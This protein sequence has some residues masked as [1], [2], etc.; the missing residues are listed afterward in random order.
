MLHDALVESLV[1]MARLCFYR[2]D[3]TESP[4]TEDRVSPS[5]EI[6]DKDGVKEDKQTG[7]K[8]KSSFDANIKI[9]KTLTKSNFQTLLDASEILSL[10]ELVQKPSILKK[11]AVVKEELINVVDVEPEKDE[12]LGFL[13]EHDYFAPPVVS[14][15]Q[16]HSDADSDGTVSAE[17]DTSMEVFMDHNYCLPPKVPPKLEMPV[18]ELKPELVKPKENEIKTEI[19]QENKKTPTKRKPRKQKQQTLSDIT[20]DTLQSIN[21]LRGSRELANLLESIKPIPKFDPRTFDAERKVFFDMYTS[22]LDCED[23]TFLKRTYENLLQSED[24]SCYWIN[25]ILWVDHPFTNI[26]DPV[27]PRKR[28]K[29]EDLPKIHSTG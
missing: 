23:I 13:A 27:P 25:D 15:E 11:K 3:K 29:L 4:M 8:A 24:P 22:G 1:L 28:R 19:P 6:C 16:K 9:A 18:E 14:A 26:P 5:K 2:G 12:K 7:N 21:K 10:R 17:E 20:E